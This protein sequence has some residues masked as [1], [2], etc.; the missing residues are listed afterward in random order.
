MI[1][2]LALGENPEIVH[3]FGKF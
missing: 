2:I 3:V 1:V